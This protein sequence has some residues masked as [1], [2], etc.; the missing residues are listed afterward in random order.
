[1]SKNLESDPFR[2]IFT[3]LEIPPDEINDVN[4]QI[5]TKEYSKF[6]MVLYNATYLHRNASEEALEL[7]AKSKFNGGISRLLPSGTIV[8]HKF[9]ECGRDD[10]MTFSESAIIYLKNNPYLL[11]IMTKGSLLQ[12]QTDLVS[13]LSGEVFRFMSN[14]I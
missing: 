3:D 13:E 6:L 4:Y 12:D 8:A 9:G 1:L 14:Y 7:L 2:K 10:D 11:T 5:N